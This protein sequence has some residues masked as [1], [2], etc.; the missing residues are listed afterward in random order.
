MMLMNLLVGL[1]TMLIC[2]VLQASLTFR[3]VR[4]Y[5]NQVHNNPTPGWL[6]RGVGPLLVVMVLLMLGNF[7]QIMIWG[8]LF[9]GLGQFD[10]IYEAVYHSG[11]NFTSLGYGDIV[12]QQQWKML[13]PLE[14]ANGVLMFGMTGAALMAVLQALIK[15]QLNNGNRLK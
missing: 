13:G 11:V 6:G 7:I 14:A 5:I 9:L 4:F 2:L 15:T 1:P 3:A 12:M 8:L 10:Q